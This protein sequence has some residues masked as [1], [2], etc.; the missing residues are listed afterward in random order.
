[1]L[2][3]DDA[4]AIIERFGSPESDTVVNPAAAAAAL[5]PE[6]ATDTPAAKVR[7]LTFRAK[8]LRVILTERAA[9]NG[10]APVWK[11]TGFLD[12]TADTVG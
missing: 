10:G 7:V 12:L 6:G 8:N 1:V 5:G 3:R 9:A 4:Q 2:A 11:L